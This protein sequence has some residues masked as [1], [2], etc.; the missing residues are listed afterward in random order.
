MRNGYRDAMR[1]F[2]KLLK[3]VFVALREQGNLSIIYVDESFLH[4]DN[5]QECYD[6]I[7]ATIKLLQ[8]LGFTISFDK[9]IL[10]PTRIIIF[11][12]FS[13]DSENMTICPTR[14]KKV[15]I[16]DLAMSILKQDKI[17]IRVVAKL[18]GHMAASFIAVPYGL[19]RHHS[20]EK[21]KIRAPRVSKGDF[22]GSMKLNKRAKQEINWWIENIMQATQSLCDLPVDMTIVSD[23]SKLGWRATDGFS[24]INGRWLVS[25]KQEHINYL[26][27]LSAEHAVL[28]FIN[29][30]I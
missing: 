8:A 1:V 28:S 6:N 9:S 12:G 15:G 30:E 4:G 22:N 25:E 24:I 11:L 17:A 29:L 13:I 3:P 19:L 2:T 14:E 5:E 21:S 7:E 18:L 27:M 10:T 23:A 20:I 16:L 26:E